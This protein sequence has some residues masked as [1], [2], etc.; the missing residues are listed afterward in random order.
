VD[1]VAACR[2]VNW[3]RILLTLPFLICTVYD[4]DSKGL[5][6]VYDLDSVVLPGSL[7]VCNYIRVGVGCLHIGILIIIDFNWN[8]YITVTQMDLFVERVEC[9]IGNS[10]S[11]I[12][13][14]QTFL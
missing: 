12:V 7:L 1:S 4:L 3:I 10:L 13:L 9:Q 14:I 8:M 5:V 6:V 11:T 2:F